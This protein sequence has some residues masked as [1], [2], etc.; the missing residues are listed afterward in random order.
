MYI[1]EVLDMVRIR[2]GTNGISSGKVYCTVTWTRF[3]GLLQGVSVGVQV[4]PV[5]GDVA[6]AVTV[7]DDG[8][9]PGKPRLWTY[10]WSPPW[11]MLQL[12]KVP[13]L[14]AEPRTMAYRVASRAASAVTL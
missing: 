11:S 8:S 1:A 5:A 12:E 6:E 3:P 2:L 7:K 9:I 10:V 13:G 4:V 14:Q